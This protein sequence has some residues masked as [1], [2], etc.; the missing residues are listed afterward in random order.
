MPLS[1]VKDRSKLEKARFF[2]LSDC[3]TALLQSQFEMANVIHFLGKVAGTEYRR[4]RR[5]SDAEAFPVRRRLSL[6]GGQLRWFRIADRV[7]NQ[8]YAVGDAKFVEDI[9]QIVFDR[10]LA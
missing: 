8:F 2:T 5:I 3:V 10:V 4:T 1:N 9:E 6:G 7:Q